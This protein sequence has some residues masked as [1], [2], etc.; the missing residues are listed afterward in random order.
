[1]TRS[2]AK[3]VKEAIELFAQATMDEVSKLISQGTSFMLG[4]KEETKCINSV[5]VANE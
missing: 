1:M 4:S 2:K 5:Q 3:P